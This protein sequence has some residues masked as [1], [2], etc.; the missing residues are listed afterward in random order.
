M[1]RRVLFRSVTAKRTGL[2]LAVEEGFKKDQ[3]SSY[4]DPTVLGGS[5]QVLFNDV[6]K[7]SVTLVV[8][9]L[10]T[11]AQP[12]FGIGAGYF[13]TVHE[14]PQGFFAS[15]ADADTAA[16]LANRLGGFG[17]A[18]L[19]GGVQFRVSRIT[20]FGQYMVTTGAPNDRLVDTPARRLLT[21]PT[22]AFT[23]GVRFG[24]GRSREGSDGA[25]GTSGGD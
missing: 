22:H 12:Y 20:L 5:R 25:S 2:I 6:R 7:Y 14:Y 18:S 4:A 9:P 19:V 3:S 15:P 16:A 21:G 1:F 13:H 23:G 10:N 8:F 24:L 17:F 11:I